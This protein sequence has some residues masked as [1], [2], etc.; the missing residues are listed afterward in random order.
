MHG[1]YTLAL[2][3]QIALATSPNDRLKLFQFIE[4]SMCSEAAINNRSLLARQS[5]V[6]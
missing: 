4:H 3:H 6:F 2:Q 1:R 5:L